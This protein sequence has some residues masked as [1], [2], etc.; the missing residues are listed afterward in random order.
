MPLLVLRR[1]KGQRIMIG[2][3][4]IVSVD[5]FNLEEEEVCL[6]ISAPREIRVD[7]EEV[8]VAKNREEF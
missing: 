4:I 3:D 1:K 5:R 2:D 8:R 6:T 7:R